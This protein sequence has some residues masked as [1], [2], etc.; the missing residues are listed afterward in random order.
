M[1]KDHMDK[2]INDIQQFLR[3]ES[4]REQGEGMV[5][6]PTDARSASDKPV[7]HPNFI[8]L[9]TLLP[10]CVVGSTTVAILLLAIAGGAARDSVGTIWLLAAG[11][12]G[13]FFTAMLVS[14]WKRLVL[15]SRIEKNT[16]LILATRRETHELLERFIQSVT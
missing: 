13:I 2:L 7:G 4:E 8:R 6:L 12:C 16:R 5:L 9:I 1:N 11:G 15:L 14:V 10:A 3:E